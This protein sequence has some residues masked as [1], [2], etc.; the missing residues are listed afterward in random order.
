MSVSQAKGHPPAMSPKFQF[1]TT[2][3]P[4]RWDEVGGI[5]IGQSRVT[6]DSLLASYHNG[7]TPEEIAVQYPV[8]GSPISYRPEN[9]QAILKTLQQ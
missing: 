6:L 8:L 7:F 2:A 5:R 4:F 3:P 9:N 1:Q